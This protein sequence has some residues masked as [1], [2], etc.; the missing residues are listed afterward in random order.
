MVAKQLTQGN[1]DR[2]D[3]DL[4]GLD[5]VILRVVQN[6]FDDRVPEFVLH[7]CVDLVDPVGE[8]LVAQIQALAHLAVLS[9]EA[10]QHPDRA[11]GHRSVRAEY[12]RTGLA[13]GDGTQ[14]LD[15][16]VVVVGHHHRP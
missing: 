12:Q 4:G 11:V 14:A 5:S 7:Q 1:L 9:A 8:D 2:E 3:G 13:L 16:L 6:E 15:C 10:G